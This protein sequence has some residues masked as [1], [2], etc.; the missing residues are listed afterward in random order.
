[1]IKKTTLQKK[2]VLAALSAA[3]TLTCAEIG[4]MVF[5]SLFPLNLVPT[6]YTKTVGVVNWPGYSGCYDREGFSCYTINSGGWRDIEHALQKPE[7]TFRIAVIGDS[8]VEAL[9]VELEK[10][11]WKTLESKLKGSGKKVEVLAFGMSGFDVAQAYY[12]LMHHAIPY[13]PDLVIFVFRPS[14]D[15]RD[16]VRRLKNIPWKPYFHLNDNGNLIPD[17]SFVKYIERQNRP[18][19]LIYRKLRNSSRV[20]TA[21]DLALKN[22]MSRSWKTEKRKT[23]S[24]GKKTSKQSKFKA[25]A[26]LSGKSIYAKPQAGGP[27]DL[28]WKVSEKLILAMREMARR[29]KAGFVV[30]GATGSDRLYERKIQPDFNP[31]YPEERMSAFAEKNGCTICHWLTGWLKRE[32]MGYSFTVLSRISEEDTGTKMAM[33]KSRNRFSLFWKNAGCFPERLLPAPPG[34]TPDT[35][36]GASTTKPSSPLSSGPFE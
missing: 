12:V 16:A 17:R 11:F 13:Q 23:R 7:R 6:H 34:N 5:Q 26:S 3:L 20:F 29:N 18:S 33:L 1:M 35:I 31:F 14:N 19:M 24:K 27:Y 15:L 32:K 4:L 22:F 2:L 10:T 8:Y 25:Q 30:V 21:A 9:Q 28:A 36:F